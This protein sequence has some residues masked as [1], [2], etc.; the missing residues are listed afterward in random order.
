M[1]SFFSYLLIFL[2]PVFAFAQNVNGV[3]T[4]FLI[5]NSTKQK[6]KFEVSLSEYKGNITGYSYTTF[7]ANDTFYYSIKKIK[8]SI[9]NNELIIEDDEMLVNNFPERAAKGVKQTTIIPVTTDSMTSLSGK[10]KTNQTKTF[11]SVTGGIQLVREVDREQSDLLAHLDELEQQKNKKALSADKK[12]S[13]NKP[14]DKKPAVVKTE[15]TKKPIETKANIPVI[16]NSTAKEEI[17]NHTVPINQ[18]AQKE[19]PINIAP[20]E[21][22][23]AVETIQTNSAQLNSVPVKENNF[24]RT[25]SSERKSLIAERKTISAQTITIT[26]DSLLLSFYDNGIV[27]GDSISVYLNGKVVI[28]KERL[29]ERAMKRTIYITPDMPDSMQ[30]VLYAENLGTIPPNTGLVIIRDGGEVYDV[31]FSADFSRNAAITIRRRK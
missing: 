31:R 20:E 25:I 22:K 1:K 9:K 16:I 13:K 11:Y 24:I 27:D 23:K 3:W 26:S 21:K 10:W 8:A 7:V 28:D 29:S 17:K 19:Q 18:P 2:L 15:K 14:E 6:Q 5:N 4:G 30:L 12:P